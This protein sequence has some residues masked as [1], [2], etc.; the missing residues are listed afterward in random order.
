MGCLRFEKV[1]GRRVGEHLL[2]PKSVVFAGIQPARVAAEH[3]G[4]A[5]EA[6]R[7]VRS[8]V[9]ALTSPDATVEASTLV[10][11]GS[12]RIPVVFEI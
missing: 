3:P 11:R 5:T 4:I 10:A 6:T 1:N 8:A 7:Q 9:F 12:G 2:H